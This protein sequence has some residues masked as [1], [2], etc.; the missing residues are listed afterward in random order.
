MPDNF[1]FS[2]LDSG[3]WFSNC[4]E[5]Y[6]LFGYIG[7]R[8]RLESF[9]Q[10]KSFG[11]SLIEIVTPQVKISSLIKLVSGFDLSV[12]AG[13]KTENVVAKKIIDLLNEEKHKQ[14][15]SKFLVGLYKRSRSKGRYFDS[16][17]HQFNRKLAIYDVPMNSLAGEPIVVEGQLVHREEVSQYSA[18][19]AQALSASS[20]EWVLADFPPHGMVKSNDRFTGQV[21]Q[22]K[23]DEGFTRTFGDYLPFCK[24]IGWYPYCRVIGFFD[25]SRVQTEVYPTLSISLVEYRRPRLLTNVGP[26]VYNLLERELNNRIYLD[27]WSDDLLAGY[28]LALSALVDGQLAKLA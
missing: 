23:E 17:S 13:A 1:Y 19:V 2:G 14:Q 12:I 16:V 21:L 7:D 24:G 4:F 22:L 11:R 3:A 18:D 20:G 8:G 15:L 6:H 9:Q 27:D 5:E 26:A 28:L 10:Q 25:S